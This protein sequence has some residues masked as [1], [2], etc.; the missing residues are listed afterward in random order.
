M[1]GKKRDQANV[2]KS[3]KEMD[4]LCAMLSKYNLVGNPREWL[5]DSGATHHI[6][7]NKELF[8][9]FAPAQ[10]EEKIY[11]ANSAAAKVKGT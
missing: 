1:K 11:M 6:C 4:D 2:A 9:A 5:I 3:K 8:A 7:A 10:W